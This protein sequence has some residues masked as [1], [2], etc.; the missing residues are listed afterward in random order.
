MVATGQLMRLSMDL[1]GVWRWLDGGRR[2]E[3]EEEDEEAWTAIGL[4]FRVHSDVTGC[5]PSLAPDLRALHEL[6]ARLVDVSPA[7]G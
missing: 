2:E 5:A 6:Q 1:L 3:E 4:F 7:A